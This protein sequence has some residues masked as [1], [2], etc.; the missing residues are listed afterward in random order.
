[1]QA[2]QT[3]LDLKQLTKAEMSR[4]AMQPPFFPVYVSTTESLCLS[5]LIEYP[6][7]EKL[8]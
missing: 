5:L 7:K 1:M 4:R 6:Y 2:K 3:K 8:C